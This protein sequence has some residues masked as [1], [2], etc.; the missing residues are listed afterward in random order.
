[1]QQKS[2]SETAIEG[3]LTQRY[4]AVVAT[5]GERGARA[6]AASSIVANDPRVAKAFVTKDRAGLIEAM[7]GVFANARERLRLSTMSFQNLDGTN[8]ARVH[9]PANFG[10]DVTA[11]RLMVRDVIDSGQPRVGIEPGLDNLSIFASVPV[12]ADG[13]LV[14]I[15]DVGSAFDANSLADL[16]QIIHVDLAVHV[17]TPGKLQTIASTFPEKSLLDIGTHTGAMTQV[18]QLV[19]TELAGRPVAVAAGPLKNYSGKV[20][21]TI[22]IAMDATTFVEAHNTAVRTLLIVLLGVAILGVVTALALAKH[23]GTPIRALDVSMDELAAGR[24]DGAIASLE[25]RDEIGEMARSLE[26]LRIALAEAAE[27]RAAQERGRTEEATRLRVRNEAAQHFALQMAEISNSFVESSNDVQVAAQSLSATAEETARQTQT[28]AGAAE[29]AS[30]NV[31]T[32]ASAAEAMNAAVHDIST[33]VGQAARIAN[34]AAEEAG[35]T[36]SN[37]DELSQSAEAIGQVVELINSIAAQTNLLA[38]NATIEAARAGDAGKGFAVVAAEV[39]QLANQTTKATE[40]IGAK[41]GEI[42][43]A[44][45]RT[46]GSIGTIAATVEQIRAI[47]DQVASAV[48]AQG[49][50][51]REIAGN[52]LR[53]AQGTEMV[54]DNIAGVGQAAEMT[55][56]ASTQLMDLSNSLTARAGKLKDEVATFVATL[57]AA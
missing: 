17:V 14:G 15:A 11:R 2:L 54:T 20:I 9:L 23:L 30:A 43:S 12:L 33:K 3:A 47:S 13:K 32:V 7:K 16:K 5:I 40:V 29:E 49:S 18:S 26:K 31:R 27:M 38:L 57:G 10:D 21:G 19:M 35:A 34:Q 55:G 36:K 25:R 46:V 42:Q 39:K 1:M 52:T 22:E 4:E 37:I 6:L 51:S 45:E 28:V 8:F 48:E 50:A 53:A 56:A 44:T 24:Y 41:I